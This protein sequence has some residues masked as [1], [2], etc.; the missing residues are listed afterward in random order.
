VYGNRRE[1]I[2]LCDH[3]ARR[4]D[5]PERFEER[6]IADIAGGVGVPAGRIEIAQRYRLQRGRG[7]QRRLE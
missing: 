3:V 7:V 4:D 1:K 6:G 2:E 5:G